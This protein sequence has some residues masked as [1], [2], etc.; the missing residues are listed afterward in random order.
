MGCDLERLSYT[1]YLEV[2][3]LLTHRGIEI[4]NYEMEQVTTKAG[5][6]VSGRRVNDASLE[7]LASKFR[8]AEDMRR[9]WDA[10]ISP[11]QKPT[12]VDPISGRYTR[13]A[14]F[15]EIA[16]FTKCYGRILR[17]EDT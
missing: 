6:V 9:G 8:G 7:G 16:N 13:P 1:N 5:Q 10:P 3:G 17:G 4:T 12:A 2:A 14:T 15:E 11:S